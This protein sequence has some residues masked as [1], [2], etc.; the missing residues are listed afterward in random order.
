MGRLFGWEGERERK[1]VGSD[2][3]LSE[4]T[5]IQSS[6][7]GRK[8]ERKG[9][10]CVLDKITLPY[11]SIDFS[12]CFLLFFHFFLFAQYVHISFVFCFCFFFFFLGAHLK[13]FVFLFFLFL[14]SFWNF[15]YF[16]NK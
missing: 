14:G 3:F 15:S 2:Y 13:F 16:I 6:Q 9:G 8:L 11:L 4:L 12:F 5:K 1:V 10:T 7:N